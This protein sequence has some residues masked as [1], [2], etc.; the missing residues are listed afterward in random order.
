MKIRLQ[1]FMADCGIA[2]RRECEEMITAGRVRVNGK[3]LTRM[4]VLIDPTKDTI[5]VD[6]QKIS[7]EG[8]GSS[9]VELK[10][11]TKVYR[12]GKSLKKSTKQ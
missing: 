5:T 2:S 6:N 9:P 10:E 12:E 3:P 4:P 7:E 1:R 11:Q 8:E